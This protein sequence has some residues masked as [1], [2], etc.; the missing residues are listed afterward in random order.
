MSLTFQPV[1]RVGC[2]GEWRAMRTP[3]RVTEARLDRE[4]RLAILRHDAGALNPIQFRPA[5]AAPRAVRHGPHREPV[6]NRSAGRAGP[7]GSMAT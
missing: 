6:C 4:R 1:Y 2:G 7:E 3:A 5:A